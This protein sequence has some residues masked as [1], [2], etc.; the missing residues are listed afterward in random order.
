MEQY[1]KDFKLHSKVPSEIIEKYKELVPNEVINFW[2][3]YGFG[4]FMQ[5]YFKSVNPEE[6]KDIL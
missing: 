4:T 2:G 6:F 1:L 3:N 5:G